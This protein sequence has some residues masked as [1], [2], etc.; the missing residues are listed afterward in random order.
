MARLIGVAVVKDERPT[1]SVE[2][3]NEVITLRDVRYCYRTGRDVI[4]GVDLVIRP[5]E[6]LA[7]VG[8]SGAGKSTL[9]RLIA[10]IDGPRTGSVTVGGV[11]LAQMPLSTPCAATSRW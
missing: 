10:G 4:H 9:G 7:M 2:P 1:S 3:T 11:S 6:R 5:G 8:P